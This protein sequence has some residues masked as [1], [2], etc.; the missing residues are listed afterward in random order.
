MVAERSRSHP[1]SGQQKYPIF[2]IMENKLPFDVDLLPVTK[3]R[4]GSLT[5][6]YE[7]GNLR[8]IESGNAELIRMIY[9]AVRDENW[10]TLPYD[11]EEERVEVDEHGFA[12]SYTATYKH[13]NETVYRAVFSL[14][15]R[16]DNTIIVEMKGEALAGFTRNRIGL[17]VLHPQ[18]VK[19]SAVEVT[20][21][22][23]K[24]VKTMFSRLISP[25]QV[26]MDIR[27]MKYDLGSK[28]VSIAFEGDVFETEDQRNWM[29]ASY[30]TYS[31]PLAVPFPVT[32]KAGDTVFNKVTIK[33]TDNGSSK[34]VSE[35]DITTAEKF[36]F[37]AIG[38]EKNY[39][40]PLN[41]DEIA[42][43][44]TV[45][46]DHYRVELD[47]DDREWEVRL[48]EAAGEARKLGT[49]LELVV[50]FNNDDE[51]TVN[52]VADA[53]RV[54]GGA[55]SHVL[56]LK[57]GSK[58]TPPNLQ[59]LFYPLI[60][61]ILPDVLVG[62]GS[63]AYFT[64][65]NRERPQNELFD[66]VSFPSHPQAHANDTRTIIENLGTG[67]DI[68]ATIRSFTD[69]PIYVSPLTISRRRNPDARNPGA[70]T[71]SVADPRQQTWLGVAWTLLC[72]HS[73][74]GA[75][76]VTMYQT[77]GEKGILHHEKSFFMDMLKSIS[78]FK[79]V[80]ISRQA[81]ISECSVVLENTRGDK[82][83]I[84]FDQAFCL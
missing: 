23:G 71:D 11:I 41:D 43:L 26:L 59:R 45:P 81:D 3:L 69:K 80:S 5:C 62:Y 65:V 61:R 68:I 44:R 7:H 19:G 38:Y 4:A 76:R 63:D 48:N 35:G 30:K 15:G 51:T 58:V 22:D 28:V 9:S 14:E 12:I 74:G 29:D 75:E 56:P 21:P 67:P 16:Q 78:E 17:C 13:H 25:R 39:A 66:F 54:V 36:A 24:L 70:S 57:K 77:T 31:T 1:W 32:V 73:L 47:L 84:K 37:P 6:L 40:R 27:A 50:F 18:D 20:D 60:K 83:T 42:L 49:K 46:F 53:L 33:V 34:V 79:P 82:K 2:G 64:E 72:L 55:V 8:R 10:T 52:N